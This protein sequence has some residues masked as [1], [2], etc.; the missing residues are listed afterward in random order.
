MKPSML[1]LLIASGAFGAST[2]Y[3]ALQLKEERA[4]ADAIAEQTARLNHR[5]AELERSRAEFESLRGETDPRPAAGKD[6]GGGQPPVAVATTVAE[7]AERPAAEPGERGVPFGA[8]RSEAMQKMARAQMRANFKRMNAD[9][10]SKLGLSQEDAN[11]LID[12]MIDQ[13]MGMIE[14]SREMRGTSVTPEQRAAEL[15]AQQQKNLADIT[16]LIGAD[17][18]D[19]YKDYQQ[20]MPARQEVD[21]LSRQ[22]PA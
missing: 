16:A 20:T 2:I 19:A 11:K 17:K 3:L 5:I 18:I 14:R 15:S 6:G 9:I 22:G 12:L 1:G 7:P 10:G 13:Q 4:Q 21:M 8:P